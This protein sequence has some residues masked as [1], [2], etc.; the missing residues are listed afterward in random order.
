MI[1]GKKEREKG[2]RGERAAAKVLARLLDVQ[3]IRGRQHS[4][5]PESPDVI[6]KELPLH[7]EVK[8]DESTISNKTLRQIKACKSIWLVK[9]GRRVL[10]LEAGHW[11]LP[12]SDDKEGTT[13][14]A[15]LKALDQAERDS[16]D[17]VVPFVMSRRNHNKWY[18]FIEDV[19]V[20]TFLRIVR[21]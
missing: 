5:S 11:E 16:G 13:T 18:L 17:D 21:K 4:G 7:V 1:M 15:L 3:A 8:R 20:E 9:D 14:K 2:K 12:S 19:H 6:I 10:C